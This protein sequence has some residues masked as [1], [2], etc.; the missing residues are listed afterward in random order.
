MKEILVSI[1]SGSTAA[2]ALVFLL[3]G[4][5]TER[6]K[7]SIQHE[8]AQKLENHKTDLNTRIQALQHEYQLNQLRTSLFFDHQREA[9]TKIIT[10]IAVAR[11]EWSKLYDPEEELEPIPNAAYRNVK[12]VYNLNR[13]FLDDDCIAS[14]EIVL[15]VMSSSF[16]ISDGHELHHRDCKFPYDALIFMQDRIPDVFQEKIGLKVNGRAKIEIALFGAV[17]L[18]NNYHFTDIGLPPKNDLK[19]GI[20]DSPE[21]IVKRGEGNMKILLENLN[22]FELYISKN[23]S[24]FGD[25]LP[26]ISRLTSMLSSN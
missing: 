2:A 4:W 17:R 15:D 16:P 18:L 20:Q 22:Q 19:I 8:Y 26:K 7:Q 21:D 6:I 5:L 9:F 14:V 1:L 11:D 23:P 3:R 24:C 13:L 10:S 25:I 12:D